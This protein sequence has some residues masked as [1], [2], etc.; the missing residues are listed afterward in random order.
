ML[1]VYL[2]AVPNAFPTRASHLHYTFAGSAEDVVALSLLRCAAVTLAHC[3][4]TG[5]LFQRWAAAV[6]SCGAAPT[7]ELLPR[8]VLLLLPCM[9]GAGAVPLTWGAWHAVPCTGRR[10]PPA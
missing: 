10:A 5:P 1:A 4:G 3:L 7:L 8:L 9:G 2:A 6:G